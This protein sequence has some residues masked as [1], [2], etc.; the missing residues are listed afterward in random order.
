MLYCYKVI[1]I[2]MRSREERRCKNCIL[3]E[4]ETLVPPKICIN[5]YFL[6]QKK[7]I[8]QEI[9]NFYKQKSFEWD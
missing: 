7:H 2:S 1:D 6:R 8:L 4:V 9:T 3:S 5:A